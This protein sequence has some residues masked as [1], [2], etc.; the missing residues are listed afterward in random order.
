[1]KKIIILILLFLALMFLTWNVYAGPDAFGKADVNKDGIIS[2]DEFDRAIKAR[3]NEYDTNK[4]GKIDTKEFAVAGH[5]E[6]AK[7]FK[8]MD[9]NNDGFVSSDEFYKAALQHR[10]ELDF[11]RDGKISKEEYNSTKALPFLR[12][13]F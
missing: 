5:P 13:Y 10:D 6:A 1:M 12:F 3:F 8:F 2:Q 11:S 4:D 7:E 9:R